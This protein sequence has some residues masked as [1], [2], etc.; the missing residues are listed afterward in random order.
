MFKWYIEEGWKEKPCY[1]NWNCQ[2]KN[3]T[4]RLVYNLSCNSISLGVQ[5]HVRASFI[6]LALIFFKIRVRSY[7][8]SSFFVKR[9]AWRSCSVVNALTTARCRYHLFTILRA[10]G[11]LKPLILRHFC[12]SPVRT[13]APNLNR[14]ILIQNYGSV[15]LHENT[16]TTGLF[17]KRKVS[18]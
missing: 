7:R 10:F 3:E 16:V 11:T 8:G 14:V 18:E 13:R 5:R 2:L 12:I 15:F 17:Q 4:E 6:S 9:H 1:Y